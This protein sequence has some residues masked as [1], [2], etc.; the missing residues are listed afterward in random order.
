MSTRFVAVL[1]VALATVTTV[2]PPARAD[3]IH[4]GP[5]PLAPSATASSSTVGTSLPPRIQWE[6]NYGY[7]GEVSFI[8]AGLYY[9]QYLSQYDARAAASGNAPQSRRNSQLLLGVNDTTAASAMHLAA[10]AFTANSATTA[11]AFLTWVKTNVVAGYPVVIGV[12]MNQNRFNGA[13]SPN[14]GDSDYDHIVPVTAITSAHAFS[15]PVTAY[16]DDVLTLNDGGV[17]T[18]TPTKQPQNVFNF[19]FSTFPATRQGANSPSAGLYSIKTSGNTGMAI[20][21]VID[22]SHETVPVRLATS[23]PTEN[24]EMADGSNARPTP[25]PL[26]L[27][28]TVSGLKPGTSYNL[29][30]YTTLASVP[31]ATFNANAAK[32]AQKF[33]IKITSGSSYTT[34]QTINSNEVA[35]YRAVPAGSP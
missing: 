9:G 27:T 14:A 21:G 26:T 8:S 19:P 32:A 7:C 12:L 4:P 15:T 17:W 31:N 20:T 18:G 34:T 35:V 2:M 1:T 22:Q 11:T 16:G 3:G 24:P 6:A 10:T 33:T 25:G 13:K 29:Y 28:I 5:L 30:R 23:V